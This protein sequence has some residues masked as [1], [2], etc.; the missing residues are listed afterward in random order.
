MNFFTPKSC[1]QERSS[2]KRGRWRLRMGVSMTYN[3]ESMRLRTLRRRAGLGLPRGVRLPVVLHR[4]AAPL[5][6]Q[7]GL[8]K[9][10]PVG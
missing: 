9:D 2:G 8:P 3:M 6:L 10:V 1:P 4:R 5:P 7:L